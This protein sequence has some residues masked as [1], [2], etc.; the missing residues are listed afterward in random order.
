MC[1]VSIVSIVS[2]SFEI[3]CV[4]RRDIENNGDNGDS[5][6]NRDNGDNGENRYNGNNGDIS[7]L[8]PLS[9][10]SLLSPLIHCPLRLEVQSININSNIAPRILMN[11]RNEQIEKYMHRAE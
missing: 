2:V 8:P 11:L 1:H 3:Y 6:D 10:S 7:P 5:E 4:T 9:L